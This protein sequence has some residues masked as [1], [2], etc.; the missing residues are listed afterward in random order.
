MADTAEIRSLKSLI[1]YT[2]RAA[3]GVVVASLLLSTS[4][5]AA[6]YKQWLNEEVTWIV[7]S[8]ERRAFKEL[9]GDE[10]KEEFVS[11]FW[12]R[13]DP[14]PSTQRNEYREEH[15]RRLVY[16][17]ETFREGMPGWRTDR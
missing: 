11:E 15:Y 5:E 2:G 6:N 14:T 1:R 3:A 17:N 9:K 7:S 12:R 8:E 13:R 10:A 4:A 16:V